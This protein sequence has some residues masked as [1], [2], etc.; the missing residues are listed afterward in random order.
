MEAA[1]DKTNK[2]A[3]WSSMEAAGKASLAGTRKTKMVRVKR[4]HIDFLRRL[5]PIVSYPTVSDELISRV[6]SK[7]ED[8]E[9]C[10]SL[11]AQGK[12]FVTKFQE[13]KDDI[14]RQFYKYGV[15]TREVEVFDG[16]D[17]VEA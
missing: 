1:A 3:G 10:R 14:L 9:E 4:S 5:R 12:A 6:F 8:Q 7:P 15:A 17:V 13:E 2:V 11:Q 16:D